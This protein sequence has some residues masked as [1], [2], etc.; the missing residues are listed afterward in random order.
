MTTE[1]TICV[2][3]TGAGIWYSPDSGESWKRSKM[4]LP[5]F[6]HAGDIQ[7][8]TLTASPHNPRQLFAGSEAG[9]FRS[10]DGGATWKLV[11][12]PMGGVQI[13]SIAL[14]PTDPEV[15]YA[16]TKPPAIY[17]S[18]DGGKRWEKLPA[19]IEEEC[20]IGPPRVTNLVLDPHDHRSLWAGVELGGIFHSRDG[21]NTWDHLPQ[22]GPR[23]SSQ[24]VHGVAVTS[25]GRA[26]V[27]V[28]TPDGIWS[29]ADEGKS[30][31]LHGF[32]KFAE[33]DHVSY[34]RAVT[35]KADNPEVIFVAN[36]ND[37]PGDRGA[38]QRSK[39]GGRTWEA[40]PLPVE[41]NSTIYWIATN[42]ADPDTIVANSMYGYV[43]V[44]RDGGDSWKKS[45]REFSEIRG[46]AWTP[47]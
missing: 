34:C 45:K 24:D 6:F 33:R 2:G 35:V 32:P 39:D 9:L 37:V 18:T 38:I 30:W 47:N 12:S 29:S 5:F 13:W 40:V 17:R 7:V 25:N 31:S 27:L 14:D 21:G 43:Y 42:A 26:R 44:S 15:M 11:E 20:P 36:G 41:P 8:K 19:G 1:F 28:T 46:L 3:T 4:D 23:M 16:G 22:L 10:D